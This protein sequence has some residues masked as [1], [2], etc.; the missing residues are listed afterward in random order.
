M[1][2]EGAPNSPT[3]PPIIAR[4]V[5]AWVDFDPMVVSSYRQLGYEYQRVAYDDFL[6][7]TMI[8]DEVRVGHSVTALFEVSFRQGL[9]AGALGRVATVHTKYQDPETDAEKEVILE[10]SSSDLGLAFEDATPYFQRDAVVAEYAEVLRESHWARGSGLEEVQSLAQRVEDL[11]PGDGQVAEF[12]ELV[13]QSED[14]A[15][16]NVS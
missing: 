6:T 14:I 7:S 10:F 11:F 13:T 12:A 1:A 4:N 15:T 9:L 3:M 5:K 2:P 8:A 16:T